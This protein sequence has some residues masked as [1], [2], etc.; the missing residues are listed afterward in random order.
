[1]RRNT[2]KSR[3]LD[4]QTVIGTMVQEVTN[5]S[6]AQVMKQ[7][8]FDFFMIDMEHGLFG[9]EAAAGSPAAIWSHSNRRTGGPLSRGA[10]P[11]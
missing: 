7:V 1:M 8:G 2:L 11:Y 10:T 9:L 3:L 6:I 4:G 5:P